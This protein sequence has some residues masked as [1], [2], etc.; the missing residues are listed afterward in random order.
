MSFQPGIPNATD[1]ISVSQ[2]DLKNNFTTLNTAWNVNHIGFNA[3]GAGKH[4]MVEM[5]VTT[6]P[7]TTAS[8]GA[9][10]TKAAGGRTE[11]FYRGAS[12]GPIIELSVIKAWASF[13]GTNGAL[14]DSY[15]ISG[16]V[17]NGAG[18]YTVTFVTALQNANYGVVVTPAMNSFSIGAIPGVNTL[19]TANFKI[20]TKS[21]T[22]NSG[23]DLSPVSF[24][25]LGT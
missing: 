24:V 21:L 16:V 12:S 10:Y 14:I 15:N 2:G 23:T 7:A 5:P 11:L 1:L 20:L 4:S 25:V 8:E 17:R 13:N 6:D 9:I 18:D 19:T 22:S 3:T